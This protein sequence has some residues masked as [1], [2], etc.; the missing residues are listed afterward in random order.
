MKSYVMAK[1][2]FPAEVTVIDK[3]TST[4]A[5]LGKTIHSYAC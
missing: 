1:N 3:Q 5:Q 2:S 4:V